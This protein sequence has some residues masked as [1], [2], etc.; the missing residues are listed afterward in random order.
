MLYIIPHEGCYILFLREG[1]DQGQAS[2]G[3]SVM[4]PS[5]VNVENTSELAL[6]TRHGFLEKFPG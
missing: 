6:Q 1:D 3:V 5:Q 4:S 2:L